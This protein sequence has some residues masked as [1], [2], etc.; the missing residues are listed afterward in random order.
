ML[1]LSFYDSPFMAIGRSLKATIFKSRHDVQRYSRL[2]FLSGYCERRDQAPGM[3]PS[4]L[5]NRTGSEGVKN[6]S[7]ASRSRI[8]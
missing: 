3:K 8:N 1:T 5:P 4:T 2:D 6:V 7:R